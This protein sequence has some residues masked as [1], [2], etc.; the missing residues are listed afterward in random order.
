MKNILILFC[1]ATFFSCGLSEEEKK[2]LED[3]RNARIEFEARSY[4]D[5]AI[6]YVHNRDF[7]SAK[8][9][10]KQIIDYYPT[11]NSAR[12]A[13]AFLGS[14]KKEERLSFADPKTYEIVATDHK[15][16]CKN[17]HILLKF[18]DHSLKTINAFVTGFIA[19][20]SELGKICT[21]TMYKSKSA[22]NLM[23]KYPLSKSEYKT[24][25][26]STIA[27]WDFDTRTVNLNPYQD[28]FSQ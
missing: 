7:Y 13:K 10:L 17:Y 27:L 20:Y 24:L 22:S 15:A 26:K 23:T 5:Q 19:E 8:Y 16:L 18:K 2:E 9:T 14:I 1:I 21:I 28:A 6:K 4:L 3:E 12:K 25:A 11:S